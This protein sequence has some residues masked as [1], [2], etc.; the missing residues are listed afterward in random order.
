DSTTLEVLS[1][2][3]LVQQVF[4]YNT[5]TDSYELSPTYQFNRLCSAD[6]PGVTAFYNPDTGLGYD[7]RIFMNGEET[8]DG[9]AFAHFVDGDEAGNSYEIP[10][11]GNMAF[12]NSVANPGTGDTTMVALTDDTTPGQ[13][14]FYF[15]EKQDTGTAL[16]KAGL[17]GGSLYGIKVAELD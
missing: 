6:L 16:E 8:T 2:E 1:G 11:L 10:W 3:D 14:Y 13:V 12:E 4:L 9:K 17:V 5:A 7:G 15:G